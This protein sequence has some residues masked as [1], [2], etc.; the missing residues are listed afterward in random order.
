MQ[1]REPWQEDIQGHVP[2]ACVFYGFIRITCRVSGLGFRVY[3]Y[4]RVILG[5]FRDYIG[6]TAYRGYIL[7]TVYGGYIGAILG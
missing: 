2:G 5:I 7:V 3:G 4:I 1:A 6:V